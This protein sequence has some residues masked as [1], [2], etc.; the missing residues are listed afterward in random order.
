[1][2][3]AHVGPR[4]RALVGQPLYL[5]EGWTSNDARCAAAG[6]PEAQRRYRAKIDLALE[7]LRRARALGH[8]SAE[9]AAGDDALGTSPVFRDG[10]TTEGMQYTLELRCWT[11]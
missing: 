6:V 10:L 11:G 8:L 7:M 9:W 2:F 3:L 1:M 4:G 5:P